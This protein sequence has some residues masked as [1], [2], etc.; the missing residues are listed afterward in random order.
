MDKME[1]FKAHLEPL[2]Q[3]LAHRCKAEGVAM[4][5]HFEL[6][7]NNGLGLALLVPASN[8]D[9]PKIFAGYT[10]IFQEPVELCDATTMVAEYEERTGEKSNIPAGA[11]VVYDTD[12]KP[13]VAVLAAACQGAGFSMICAV[14]PGAIDG[15]KE[16]PMFV[17]NGLDRDGAMPE[18]FVRAMSLLTGIDL[19]GINAHLEA[20]AATRLH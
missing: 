1:K 12:I 7:A 10:G 15:A 17:N 13:A 16:A 19:E 11:L 5:A 3:E 20:Q 8:G 6:P 9:V 4:F 2:L 14:A 18:V